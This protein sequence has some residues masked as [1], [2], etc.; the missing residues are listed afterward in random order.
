MHCIMC[1]SSLPGAR[2]WPSLCGK[3]ECILSFESNRRPGDLHLLVTSP[4]A[5][6]FLISL[7]AG[8]AEYAGHKRLFLGRHTTPPGGRWKDLMERLAKL[9]RPLPAFSSPAEL[10]RA[11]A[12]ADSGLPAALAWIFSSHRG[13]LI[14]LADE[15]VSRI[16]PDE[17]RQYVPD[18]S[19]FVVYPGNEERLVAFQKQRRRW[20]QTKMY[21]HGSLWPKWHTIIRTELKDLSTSHMNAG[22]SIPSGIYLSPHFQVSATYAETVWNKS[23]SLDKSR[24][25]RCCVALCEVV[26]SDRIRNQK[27]P[28]AGEGYQDEIVATRVDDVLVRCLI[29]YESSFSNAALS[30]KKH[31]NLQLHQLQ[32]ALFDSEQFQRVSAVIHRD[33]SSTSP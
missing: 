10:E 1:D 32:S 16:M 3:R 2:W 26:Q 20:R 24:Y 33:T 11:L 30:D 23:L 12:A 9:P 29:T 18:I 27:D 31:I 25:R 17:V 5:A 6:D 14:P 8:A 15:V 21:F 4:K 19:V 7:A 13:H 28:E 22:P